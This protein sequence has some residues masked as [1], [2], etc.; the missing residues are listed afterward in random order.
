MENSSNTLHEKR[1]D[2]VCEM[3]NKLESF[4]SNK[5][6]FSAHS[7]EDMKLAKLFLSKNMWGQKGCPFYLE[8]PYVDMPSMLKDKITKHYLKIEDEK[9]I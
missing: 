4:F 5:R 8:W 1:Q 6:N 7:K 2:G 3:N 9:I